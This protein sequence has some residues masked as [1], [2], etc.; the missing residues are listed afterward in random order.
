[1]LFVKLVK[2]FQV[3]T[4]IRANLQQASALRWHY[5]NRQKYGASS[6]ATLDRCV[7]TWRWCADVV[8]GT[9]Q[10]CG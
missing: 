1:M 6:C 8:G 9:V 7:T 3:V 2:P 4:Q 5:G 10:W